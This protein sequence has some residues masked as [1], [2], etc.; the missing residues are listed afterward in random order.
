LFAA[1]LKTRAPSTPIKNI[2][3]ITIPSGALSKCPEPLQSC[4]PLEELLE[5]GRYFSWNVGMIRTVAYLVWG[6]P[7]DATHERV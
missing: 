3:T 4:I 1:S 5:G 6:V 7:S 2:G